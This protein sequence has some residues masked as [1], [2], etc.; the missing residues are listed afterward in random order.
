MKFPIDRK[1]YTK[2]GAHLWLKDEGNIIQVGMDAFVAEMM[3][4]ISTIFVDKKTAKCGEEIGSFESN[5]YINKLFSPVSGE[6]I[7]VNDKI[8]N[9]PNSINIDPYNSWIFKIRPDKNETDTKHIL[10]DED[11]ILS[12]IKDEIKK[13]EIK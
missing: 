5:K 7:Y 11:N 3:G 1:Y 4:C 2:N 8:L 12:W 13:I 9:N 10:E 6:I